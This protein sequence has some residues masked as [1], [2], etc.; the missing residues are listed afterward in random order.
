LEASCNEVRLEADYVD[1]YNP[2]ASS[3]VEDVIAAHAGLLM[4]SNQTKAL[5]R[6]FAEHE[7]EHLNQV[8]ASRSPTKAERAR[9]ELQWKDTLEQ[10][11]EN[12]RQITF[13][14]RIKAFVACV[15]GLQLFGTCIRNLE[16]IS[17]KEK[18]N[19]LV[20]F[21]K[22]W[23]ECVSYL[24]GAIQ[25]MIVHFEEF[26]KMVR[27]ASPALIGEDAEESSIDE[28]DG[29]GVTELSPQMRH[30]L[31]KVF[32]MLAPTLASNS[33]R[34]DL[35]TERLGRVLM[36]SDAGDLSEGAFARVLHETLIVDMRLDG[37]L[38]RADKLLGKLDKK[39]LGWQFLT[40][41]LIESFIKYPIKDKETEQGLRDLLADLLVRQAGFEKADVTQATNLL[42]QRLEQKRII[43]ITKTRQK[44]I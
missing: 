24:L 22:R 10:M 7:E 32:I 36:E 29:R 3:V 44:L 30:M 37:F 35:G 33:I 18:A 6:D 13:D 25:F 41:R 8:L 14:Q 42:K 26:N 21:F 2:P 28:D 15:T 4:E 9:L 17:G 40:F 43:E 23:A 31:E 16:Q 11:G 12:V 34:H 19:N 1:R 27:A 38:A 39:S 5:Q 20:V